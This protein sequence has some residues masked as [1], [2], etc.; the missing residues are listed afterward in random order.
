MVVRFPLREAEHHRETGAHR[1]ARRGHDL[2]RKAPAFFRRPAP[3]VRSGVARGA[4]ELVDQVAVG[5]VD[6]DAVETQPLGVSR[7]LAEGLDH[8]LDF[9]RR[10]CATAQAAV[11]G[12]DFDRAATG[13]G[14]A[15]GA[16]NAHRAGVPE[17]RDHVAAGRVHRV[18]DALPAGQRVRAVKARHAVAVGVGRGVFD[19]RALGDDQPDPARRAA[20]VV[21]GDVR[22]GHAA[23]AELAR[24]RRH[25]QAVLQRGGAEAGGTEQAVEGVV[26]GT[27]RVVRRIRGP[28]YA[29]RSS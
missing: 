12:A 14:A 10:Q 26:H 2:E 13:L 8:G 18:D 29:R 20:P 19:Q 9:R 27:V 15:G 21:L 17:L 25:H 16:G 11:V 5:A 7:G 23:G 22:T 4:H 3:G 28:V 24:H 6:L 1:G